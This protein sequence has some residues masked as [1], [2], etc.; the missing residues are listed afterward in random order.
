[1]SFSFQAAV[2]VSEKTSCLPDPLVPLDTK[3]RV[4][5]TSK[6]QRTSSSGTGSKSL[7]SSSKQSNGAVRT[8]GDN[9]INTM[10][11][12]PSQSGTSNNANGP[13]DLSIKSEPVESIAGTAGTA[14]GGS[15]DIRATSIDRF[16]DVSRHSI[17]SRGYLVCNYSFFKNQ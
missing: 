15:R 12:Q 6:G 16:S 9:N 7:S 8:C 17:S 14:G 5:K 10:A 2:R 4:R 3:E 11:T 13:G 1:M